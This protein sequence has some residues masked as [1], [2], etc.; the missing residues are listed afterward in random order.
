M[1][2]SSD[3][4]SLPDY[5]VPRLPPPFLPL[6]TLD[7]MCPSQPA[8]GVSNSFSDLV[9]VLYNS[10]INNSVSFYIF[11]LYPN[12]VMYVFLLII[13]GSHV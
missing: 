1:C 7:T 5:S 8:S 6:R 13:L 4:N 12:A 9:Q 11:P 3:L 2:E 10:K